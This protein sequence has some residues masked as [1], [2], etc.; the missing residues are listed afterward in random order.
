MI[1]HLLEGH[2]LLL[3]F[4]ALVLH[5]CLMIPHLKPPLRQLLAHPQLS[6][7]IRQSLRRV[8]IHFLSLKAIL[9]GDEAIHRDV[10]GDSVRLKPVQVT[11]RQLPDQLLSKL[12]LP[13]LLILTS[14]LIDDIKHVFNMLDHIINDQPP[15]SHELPRKS[16]NFAIHVIQVQFAHSAAPLAGVQVPLR[17]RPSKVAVVGDQMYLLRH[18]QRIARRILNI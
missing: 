1:V 5:F 18:G 16:L 3:P 10:V 14:L 9:S 6:F 13:V 11:T 7:E 12:L 15:F 2:E 8:I 4:V 17:G